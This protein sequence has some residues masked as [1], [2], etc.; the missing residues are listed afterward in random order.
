MILSSSVILI[1][2]AASDLAP[3]E[4][5][6]RQA[7]GAQLG[8]VLQ[9]SYAS[10][11]VLAQQIRHGAPFD[12]YLS[13]NEAFVSELARQRRLL[14]DSVRVY[15]EGRIAL[16]SKRGYDT[17]DALLKPE[18][19]HI[20]IAHPDHAPYGAAARQALQKAGL[21][22]RLKSKIV[23]AEN[24]RQA[25]Q[26]ARSGNAD[27]AIVSHSLGGKPIAGSSLIRQAGGVVAGRPHVAESRQFL[28]W[29]CGPGGRA[30]LS[31]YGLA[32]GH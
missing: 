3:A 31:R 27:A 14:P 30:V 7:A 18:V 32:A 26:F 20:A 6:L 29:L 5:A 25:Y 19:R 11:G 28:E 12:V 24:V 4:Q 9:F 16:W 22:D 17:F 8:F 13:A 2:A 21:W 15:G 23:Y 1:V 10:S